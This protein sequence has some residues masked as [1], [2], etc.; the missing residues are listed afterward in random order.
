MRTRDLFAAKNFLHDAWLDLESGRLAQAHARATL[1]LDSAGGI[2]RNFAV[3]ASIGSALVASSVPAA[4][5]MA[6]TTSEE[7]D[8][9]ADALVTLGTVT[10]RAGR[11]DVALPLLCES[12]W[13]TPERKLAQ[14]RYEEAMCAPKPSLPQGRFLVIKALGEGFF[15]EVFQVLAGLVLAQS[16]NRT[17]IIDWGNGFLYSA[18]GLDSVSSGSDMPPADANSLFT[19][20]FEPIPGVAQLEELTDELDGKKLTHAD[21]WPPRWDVNQ[22]GRTLDAARDPVARMTPA[23]AWIGAYSNRPERI[24]VLDVPISVGE[25]LAWVPPSHPLHGVNLWEALTHLRRAFLIPRAEIEH[26]A[27]TI[28]ERDIRNDP[29]VAAHIRMGDMWAA[30]PGMAQDVSA[31]PA[32]ISRGRA[33]VAE[34]LCMRSLPRVYVMTD[35][36]RAY[37]L[38][39]TRY[40][41]DMI[42]QSCTRTRSREALHCMSWPEHER[43]AREV[44]VD[45]LVASRAD[46]FIG[47]GCSH[48]SAAA[49]WWKAWK[50]GQLELV[51]P[52]VQGRRVPMWFSAK[53]AVAQVQRVASPQPIGHN[54]GAS[55]MAASQPATAASPQLI[56]MTK[57]S[58]ASTPSGPKVDYKIEVLVPEPRGVVDLGTESDQDLARA[59]VAEASVP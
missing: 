5:L 15:A 49:A 42:A 38:F 44:L 28:V 24:L 27:Q 50:P 21:I 53:V 46:A 33:R 57:V 8:C 30:H 35:G 20:L 4:A 23:T 3:T 29:F 18:R 37:D 12:L 36:Q 14:V 45:V 16:T 25:A 43:L 9:V 47:M 51:G 48:V 40:Q 55:A 41:A 7:N 1:A 19:S 31:I 2:T 58:T 54:P 22:G 13:R 39:K 32:A 10:L 59:V 26:E 17:P 52:N 34:R 56:R 11:P 6:H